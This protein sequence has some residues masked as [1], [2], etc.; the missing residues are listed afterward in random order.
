M[1]SVQPVTG[2]FVKGRDEIA[3]RRPAAADLI[4]NVHGGHARDAAL[5]AR[6]SRHTLATRASAST[7]MIDPKQ[8]GP[9]LRG[10]APLR[11]AKRDHRRY[12]SKALTR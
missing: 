8:A 6:P 3:P 10:V 11:T 4:Q 9:N 1:G 12:P 5:F 2:A 7:A